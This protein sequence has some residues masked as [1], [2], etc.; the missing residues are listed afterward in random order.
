MIEA[1][2]HER[3]VAV[4]FLDLD[5]FKTINDSLGHETGDQLLK[6]V[7]ERLQ[8]CLRPGDT[9][10]RLGGD[11][12]TLLLAD[13]AHVDDVAR[14][15][16]KIIDSFVEPFDI[17]G[18]ELFVT[19]SIGITLFPFDDRDVELL[20]KNADT[21][22]YYAKEEGRNTFQFYSAEMNVKSVKRLTLETAL[23]RALERDEFRLHY[24]PQ[25]SLTTGEVS[26]SR[27]CCAGSIPS[28]GW[29]RPASSFRSPRRPG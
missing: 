3:L 7:A 8:G 15:A 29:C 10:S 23:R 16:Q 13:V 5:R 12:F 17:A 19:P 24:Q 14:I 18:Q 25:V 11:E 28:S 4:M 20:L 6:A 2:R 22:M 27:R 9:A 1:A 26:A 21:A